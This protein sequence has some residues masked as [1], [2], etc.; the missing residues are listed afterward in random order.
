MT[1]AASPVIETERLILRPLMS[2]DAPAMHEM[3]SDA[4]TMRYW[5]T[6]PH[7]SLVETETWV[8]EAVATNRRGEGHDFAVLHEARVIGRSAFWSGNEVGFLFRRAVWGR[9]FAGEA[10]SAMLRFGF[11]SLGFK[12]ARADVDPNNTR[13]LQLLDRLGFKERGRAQRTFK[14]GDEWFDSIYL[15]LKAADF[16]PS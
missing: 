9:G 15:T 16:K 1:V 2:Y 6:L 10:M 14:I 5:S 11:D 13:S 7:R 4:E 12:S 3:L 8:N